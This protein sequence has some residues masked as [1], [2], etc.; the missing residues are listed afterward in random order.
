M[1]ELRVERAA[2]VYPGRNGP[3][4]GVRRYFADRGAGR[5]IVA[6]GA[7]GCG[8]TTLLNLMPGFCA[9]APGGC[10]NGREVQG[11]GAE[12]AWCSSMTLCSLG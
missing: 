1:A 6:L 7:S 3:V 8:K 5:F 2:A 11:P 4:R 12:A 10:L 9:P